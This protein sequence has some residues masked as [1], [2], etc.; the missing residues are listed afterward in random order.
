[1]D[2]KYGRSVRTRRRALDLTQAQ[3]GLAIGRSQ[4]WIV[5]LER[6]QLPATETDRRKIEAYLHERAQPI[7]TLSVVRR[8][9]PPRNSERGAR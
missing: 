6:L 9:L 7:S 5:R 2:D 1:M 4:G 8:A 3:L